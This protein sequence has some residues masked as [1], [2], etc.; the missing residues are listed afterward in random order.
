MVQCGEMVCTPYTGH[1]RS[2]DDKGNLLLLSCRAEAARR[3]LCRRTGRRDGVSS[4]ASATF[5]C[6]AGNAV[7]D[8]HTSPSSPS[9]TL[10][11][12]RFDASMPQSYVGRRDG[13][14]ER[15]RRGG[16]E[17][18]RVCHMHENNGK[19]KKGEQK[20]GMQERGVGT[21]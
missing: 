21:G 12:A 6:R 11:L 16:R 15:N 18:G 7:E 19:L 14:K 17:S 1:G 10:S 3:R 5:G 13:L 9:A 4:C 20:R 8:I 2:T